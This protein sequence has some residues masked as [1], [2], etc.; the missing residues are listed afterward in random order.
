MLTNPLLALNIFKHNI[1][2]LKK[3]LFKSQTEPQPMLFIA[4]ACE[5]IR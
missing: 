4:A 5:D 3:G 1:L 2:P